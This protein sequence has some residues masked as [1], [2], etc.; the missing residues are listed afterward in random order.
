M[1]IKTACDNLIVFSMSSLVA[2]VSIALCEN[3]EVRIIVGD[4]A[5]YYT[6]RNSEVDY[7]LDYINGDLSVGRVE[8]CFQ[9]SWRSLC[10]HDWSRQD[11]SVIC[12]QLGFASAGKQSV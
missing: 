4:E 7:D 10:S 11:A 12:K 5:S 8:I 2:Y 9:Q 3:D 1:Y 6:G